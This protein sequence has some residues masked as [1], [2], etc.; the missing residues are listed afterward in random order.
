MADTKLYR[1]RYCVLGELERR[2]FSAGARS[3]SEG[4]VG[5]SCD[6]TLR[7]VAVFM[8]NRVGGEV[9]LDSSWRRLALKKDLARHAKCKGLREPPR[10]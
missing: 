2:G 3:S 8:A 4:D 5:S 1:I 7:A 6:D 10:D 9:R